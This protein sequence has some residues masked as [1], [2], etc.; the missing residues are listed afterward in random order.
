VCAGLSLWFFMPAVQERIN[1]AMLSHPD[2]AVQIR[3]SLWRDTLPMI[4]EHFVWGSGGGSFRWLYRG[5]KTHD[6]VNW[7]RYTHNEYLQYLAEYG[8][9][10]FSLCCAALIWVVARMMRFV[11]KARRDRDAYLAAA[12]VA[13]ICACLAHAAFDFNLHIYAHLQLL[14]LLGGV[15]VANLYESGELRP[16]VMRGWL[17]RIGAAV[18]IVGCLVFTVLALRMGI[19][20]WAN[21]RGDDTRLLL[22]Y[23]KARGYYRLAI[24]LNPAY[25]EPYSGLGHIGKTRCIWEFDR[26][27]KQVLAEQ[28]TAYFNNAIE[29]NP[30]DLEN[31]EG[32]SRVYAALGQDQQALEALREALRIAPQEGYYQGQL[33]LRLRLMGQDEEALEAF[34]RAR[35]LKADPEFVNLNIR[36]LKER[37]QGKEKP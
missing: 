33:A 35:Q 31:Y 18:L 8:V 12:W 24:R 23:S 3:L 14:A 16:R 27:E 34:Y 6:M 30:L 26:E 25:W 9:V 29:R 4:K 36:L 22:D 37:L 17:S 11:V 5:F 13:A 21:N 32:K 1:G 20:H 28:T 10:L 15:T 19:S 2:G 7:A